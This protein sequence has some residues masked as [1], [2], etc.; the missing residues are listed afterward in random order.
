MS[1]T[2]MA[3]FFLA[4]SVC[5]SMGTGSAFAETQKTEGSK[6]ITVE[7]LGR[8]LKSAEQN[9]EKEIPKMG[10]AIGRTVKKITSKDSDKQ[11]DRNDPKP[12][13]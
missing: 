6:G 1:R 12:K 13:K 7:D 5:L 8:G 9:V 3:V 2:T 4:V 10:S 11:S